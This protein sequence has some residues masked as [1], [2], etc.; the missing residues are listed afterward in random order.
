MEKEGG[1]S[2]GGDRFLSGA[3]NHPLSKSMVYHDQERIKACGDREIRDEIAGD[4]LEGSGGD[5]FNGRQGGHGRVCVGFVLLTKGTAFDIATDKGGE[6]RPPELGGDQLASFQEAR[7][8]GGCMI[9]TALEDG[10]AKGVVCGDID[11]AFVREDAGLDLPVGQAGAEGKRDVLVHGLEGLEDK[12]VT[13]GCRFNAVREGSVD[14]VNEKGWWEEGDVGIVRV[15]HREE[16]RS[17]GKGIGSSEEFS[18]D[19]DHFQVKVGKGNKPARLTAV[20]RLGLTEIG[21][22]LVVSENLHRKGGAVEVVAPR[23]QGANDGKEFSVINV[24]VA[25]RRGKGLR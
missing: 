6:T 3:K 10:T 21:Q 23:L 25:F 20:E 11:T 1:N 15:I 5:G 17:A 22:I 19:V 7:V 9:M 12:G 4:L 18:G 24:V 2:F 16:V 8:A 13:H 14:E